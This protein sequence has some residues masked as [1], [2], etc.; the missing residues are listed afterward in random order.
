MNQTNGNNLHKN[1]FQYKFINCRYPRACPW[2]SA[3]RVIRTN[4]WKNH[5]PISI[6]YL[7][8][9]SL[10]PLSFCWIKNNSHIT[11]MVRAANFVEYNIILSSCQY[12]YRYKYWYLQI[13][14]Y[15]ITVARRNILNT[16]WIQVINEVTEY[17]MGGNKKSKD[18]EK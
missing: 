11:I 7:S 12:K 8:I 18:K 5:V 17:R 15:C 4:R 9:Y 3:L 14:L 13:I 1:M 16:F 6:D 10:H 2:N